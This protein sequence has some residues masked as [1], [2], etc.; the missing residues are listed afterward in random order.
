MTERGSIAQVWQYLPRAVSEIAH[1]MIGGDAAQRDSALLK[2][3]AKTR[4]EQNL[5]VNRHDRISLLTQ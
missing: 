1:R 5:F 3:A 2:P 4:S